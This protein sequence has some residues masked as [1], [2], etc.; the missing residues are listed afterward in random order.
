VF[1]I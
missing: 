1:V